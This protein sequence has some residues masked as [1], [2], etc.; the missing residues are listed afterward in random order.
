MDEMNGLGATEIQPLR[1][2]DCLDL[3]DLTRGPRR[4]IAADDIRG[5]EH[6]H[7]MHAHRL[8]IQRV[9]HQRD[10]Y[11]TPVH[12]SPACPRSRSRP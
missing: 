9:S 10:S 2:L 11:L 4:G 6:G 7:E 5:A 12:P 8:A 1:Q 3:D